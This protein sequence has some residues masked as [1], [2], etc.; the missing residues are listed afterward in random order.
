MGAAIKESR[1]VHALVVKQVLTME[2]EEKSVEHPTEVKEILEEF[3]SILPEDLSEGLPPMRD[4][5]R[6]IDLILGASLPNL[7][8]YRMNPKE[9]EILKEKVEDFLKK[10]HIQESMSPCAVPALLTP[11]KDV[12][13]RMCVN[14][15]AI[16]KI[17]V[18]Y[19]FPIPRLDDMLDRLSGATMFSKIDLRSGTI[20]SRFN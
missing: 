9:S 20:K 16:N 6:H 14:S 8:H 2:E 10:G 12:S 11:K 15:M 5:Q 17:I 1:V 13:W 7:P 4:I 19:K 18:G 3:S